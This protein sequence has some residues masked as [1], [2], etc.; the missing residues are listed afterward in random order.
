MGN[1][2]LKSAIASAEA[3][4]TQIERGFDQ[5]NAVA[6]GLKLM[7]RSKTC[8]LGTMGEDGYINIKAML[9]LKHRGLKRVWFS[10]NTSSKKVCQLKNDKRAC[11]Y[12]VD[13]KSF[14]GLMLTGT[15]EVLRDLKSCRML[16]MEGS[17]VYYP[18]GIE[19]PDYT[20]LGFTAKNV[21]YY[22]GLKNI[23]FEV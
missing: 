6:A 10:T 13:E 4:K 8:M 22:H 18:G 16:W 20:V 23:T 3:G 21:N 15:M 2:A 19:D 9:N 14:E 12:Y 7:K 17:E 5:K 11:V 1:E